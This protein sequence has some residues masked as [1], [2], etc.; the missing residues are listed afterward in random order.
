MRKGEVVFIPQISKRKNVLSRERVNSN[1][2]D[3]V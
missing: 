1:S 2:Y 3:E